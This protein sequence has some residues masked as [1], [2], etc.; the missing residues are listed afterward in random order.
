MAYTVLGDRSPIDSKINESKEL[1][2]KSAAVRFLHD[3]CED[4]RFSSKIEKEEEIKGIKMGTSLKANQIPYNMQMDIDRLCLENAVKRFIDSGAVHD[5][6]D[7][8]FCYLEM[9]VGEYGKSRK[10]IELL[11]EFET[12][13]SS[14]L[15]KHRDHYSH[16]VYVFTLGLAI[17][18]TNEIYRR[19]YQKFYKLEDEQ[20]AAHHYLQYWGLASLFHDIGYPFELPFEQVASYFEVEQKDRTNMPIIA[21][22]K[23]E[24]YVKLNEKTK[25]ILA[26]IYQ[27]NDIVFKDTNELFAYDIAQKLSHT[28]DIKESSLKEILESKP[29]Y[30]EKFYYFMDHAYFSATVLFK[31]LFEEIG[32][33][34]SKDAIDALTAI[35]LHNSLYKFNI[36]SYKDEKINK[37][38]SINLHPLAFMLMLCDELQCWD[39]ISYGRNSRTELHPMNCKFLFQNNGIQAV[40]IYDEAEEPKISEFKRKYYIWMESK[41]DTANKEEYSIWKKSKPKLKAYANMAFENDF[42]SDIEKIVDLSQISLKVEIDLAKRDNHSKHTYLSNSNFIHLYNFA[43]ALNGRW[44]KQKEWAEAKKAGQEEQFLRDN[45]E[46]FSKAFGQMSLE[47]KLYNIGQAKAFDGYLDAIGC[48]Y[49]DRPVDYDMLEYFELEDVA[50]IGPMEHERWVREHYDMGWRYGEKLSLS[51]RENKRVHIDM[52]PEDM[53]EEGKVTEDNARAHYNRLEEREQAKDIE[54]MNAMLKLLRMF[55]GLRIY[56]IKEKENAE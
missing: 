50:K 28:Y 52:I 23:L 11:S 21:Y 12:N 42:Q 33:R 9:F 44:E 46:E 1:D 14:L 25:Q 15:M 41:P 48:F 31:K 32:C 2:M 40:Y 45:I 56:K 34:L 37:P 20:T 5:A 6:F 38:F 49:T 54:P 43:I 4:L 29:L 18:E 39:R 17:Y 19:E 16:S 22:Q 51:E 8:Y 53:L 35:I 55:D 26:E 10:M 3:R 36:T 30:P 7:V 47:Y 24:Q 27:L 13:S